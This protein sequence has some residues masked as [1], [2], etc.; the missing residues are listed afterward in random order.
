MCIVC[1]RDV[2]FLSDSRP[3]SATLLPLYTAPPSPLK[4]SN[5]IP[6]SRIPEQFHVLEVTD[7]SP[8]PE[9]EVLHAHSRVL[10]TS[11]FHDLPVHP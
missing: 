1:R 2:S 5:G 10:L 6:H 3:Q 8:P 7:K 9:E 4:T 11:S